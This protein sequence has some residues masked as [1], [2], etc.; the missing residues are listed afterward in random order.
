M[1]VGNLYSVL[2][3]K[4]VGILHLYVELDRVMEGSQNNVPHAAIKAG[5]G[6]SIGLKW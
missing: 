2:L 4:Q 1:G 3:E 5:Q 6:F